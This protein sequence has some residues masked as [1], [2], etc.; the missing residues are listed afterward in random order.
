VPSLLPL[1]KKQWTILLALLALN[2]VFIYGGAI[3][4]AVTSILQ[5]ELFTSADSSTEPSMMEFALDPEL[6]LAPPGASTPPLYSKPTPPKRTPTPTATPAPTRTPTP[7]KRPGTATAPELARPV[8][9][10]AALS[11]SALARLELDPRA[12]MASK[13]TFFTSACF[14]EGANLLQDRDYMAPADWSSSPDRKCIFGYAVN[15]ADGL[16]TGRYSVFGGPDGQPR[17]YII[18]PEAFAQDQQN[19][20]QLS[21]MHLIVDIGHGCDA[22]GFVG[23][24][25]D[26]VNYQC[27]AC[28]FL[29]SGG[30]CPSTDGSKKIVLPA[31]KSYILD[32]NETGGAHGFQSFP[33]VMFRK[34]FSLYF[35]GKAGGPPPRTW[36][37]SGV[38]TLLANV[39]TTA[40]MNDREIQEIASGFDGLLAGTDPTSQLA[41]LELEAPLTSYGQVSV[42]SKEKAAVSFAAP[43]GS[44]LSSVSWRIQPLNNVFSHQY[45]ETNMCLDING[46]EFCF[47]GVEDFAHCAFYTTC[48]TGFSNLVYNGRGE[49]IATRYFLGGAAPVLRD[50]KITAR[51]QG[52]DA[53]TVVEIEVKVRVRTVDA[54]LARQR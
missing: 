4:L 49:Y 20:K 34:G 53:G 33:L 54:P 36:F 31:N 43:P 1:T 13:T 29:R 15:P 3:P 30:I 51:F 17:F 37:E 21:Q 2:L 22:L 47:T 38:D 25:A 7:T 12:M 45:L 8:P 27:S 44:V 46:E 14:G 35:T 6:A 23:V 26:G 28:A 32:A 11:P 5:P 16:P 50:G 10:G 19:V 39:K 40:E 24:T 18:P 41:A 42:K 48:K 9:A 52:P